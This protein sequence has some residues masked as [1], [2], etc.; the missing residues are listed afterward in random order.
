MRR[1]ER[2]ASCKTGGLT[3]RWVRHQLCQTV[4]VPKGGATPSPSRT[5]PRN[6]FSDCF[7]SGYLAQV[8]VRGHAG[9]SMPQGSPVRPQAPART[10]RTK[11]KKKRATV[12]FEADKFKRTANGCDS[13]ERTCHN[14]PEAPLFA[15][16]SQCNGMVLTERFVSVRLTNDI[17]TNLATLVK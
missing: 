17:V 15:N 14:A 13:D 7:Y 16:Y 8:R 6:W 12:A 5:T 4:L 9:L 3:K 1:V 10:I 2:A 11:G